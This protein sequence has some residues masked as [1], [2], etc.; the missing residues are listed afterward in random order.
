MSKIDQNGTQESRSKK[1]KQTKLKTNINYF[2]EWV[3]IVT[4]GLSE[5]QVVA[6]MA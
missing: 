2:S 6:N 5:E 1:T 4:S 3:G